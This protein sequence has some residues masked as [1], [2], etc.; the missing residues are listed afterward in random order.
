MKQLT[1]LALLIFS[2]F[3]TVKA[4]TLCFGQ[5]C[6]IGRGPYGGGCT[7]LDAKISPDKN[8]FNFSSNR[9]DRNYSITRYEKDRLKGVILVEFENEFEVGTFKINIF[10]KEDITGYFKSNKHEFKYKCSRRIV[11]DI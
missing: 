10:G 5:E 7:L 4:D 11:L 1:L 6:S 9:F 8:L 2:T 3:Q